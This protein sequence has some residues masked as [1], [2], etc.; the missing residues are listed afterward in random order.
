MIAIRT[1]N[2][3]QVRTS[4]LV[5]APIKFLRSQQWLLSEKRP[6]G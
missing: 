6:M 3:V 2:R 4:R 1:P 5:H